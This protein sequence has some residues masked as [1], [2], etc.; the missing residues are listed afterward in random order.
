MRKGGGV[1]VFL[2]TGE[3]KRKGEDKRGEKKPEALRQTVRGKGSKNDFRHLDGTGGLLRKIGEAK[4]PSCAIYKEGYAASKTR[5]SRGNYESGG[6]GGGEKMVIGGK[7]WERTRRG[8][9][10]KV[11]R[12]EYHPTMCDEG[13]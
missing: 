4:G 1:G 6:G 13:N 12:K 8:K 2:T 11:S 5:E 9:E 7:D 10:K 3:G